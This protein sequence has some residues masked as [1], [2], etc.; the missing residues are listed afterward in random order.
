MET[1]FICLFIFIYVYSLIFTGFYFVK[2][3]FAAKIIYCIAALMP[4]WNTYFAIMYFKD[5]FGSLKEA[6]KYHFT[7]GK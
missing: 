7:W 6:I 3:K 1:F 4:F 2:K 5:D